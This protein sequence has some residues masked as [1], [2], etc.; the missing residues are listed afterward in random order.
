MELELED[1]VALITGGSKGIG[2]AA[3]RRYVAEGAR[4]ALLARGREALERAAA[5]LRAA[6]GEVE[7]AFADVRRDADVE[8]AVQRTV[9]RFG[10]IDIL[11]H[12][13]G[14]S[15]MAENYR[16]RAADLVPLR[17][18]GEAWSVPYP[19]DACSL[20][21]WTFT[22]D[23]NV[24]SAV[25]VLKAVLPHMRARKYG[26]IVLVASM[27]GKQRQAGQFEYVAAKAAEIA[28]ANSL[29][30]EVLKD[31]ILVNSVCPTTT[32]TDAAD[33]LAE[34][35]AA[36]TGTSPAAVLEAFGARNFPLGRLAL[37]EEVGDV[38]VFLTS[39]RASYVTGTSV[40]VDGGTGSFLSD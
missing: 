31:G 10:R 20:D 8:R 7:I 1:R 28:L 33:G 38:I 14:G 21:D 26:R 17:V 37:A 2:L 5:S 29:A 23:L 4:V 13:A 35:V 6:G 15:V 22:Y 34:I 16:Q 39:A 30:G 27:S 24:L 36:R 40:N 19:F 9:E 32:H 3:A 12:N 18:E 11:V 25:R